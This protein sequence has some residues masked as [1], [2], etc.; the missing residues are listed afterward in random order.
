MSDTVRIRPFKKTDEVKLAEY[1]N[2]KK[3]WDQLRDYLPHP[4]S[5]KDARDHIERSMNDD[6]IQNFAIIHGSEF[7]GT[8]SL[9][10]Q[11]DVY[12][13]SAETGYWIA[14]PFWGRGIATSAI[15]CIINYGF[16]QLGMA[17]IYASVMENNSASMKALIK[18]GFMAEGISKK[19][20]IKNGMYLDEHRFSILN[21]KLFK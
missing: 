13:H 17:R 21:P 15:K 11:E 5:I 20:F 19:G 3:I 9:K 16:N 12:R 6:P 7:A 8:I 14:E 1:L 2:N 10:P 18:V 4:Y